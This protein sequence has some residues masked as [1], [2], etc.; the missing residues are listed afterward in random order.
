VLGSGLAGL[1]ERIESPIVIPYAELPDFPQ[2]TVGGHPGRLLL[3]RLAGLPAAILQGR[4]HYYEDGRADAMR[5]AIDAVA[6]LGC[7]R[8][9]LTCAAGSLRA[10]VGPGSIMAVTDHLNLAGVSPL[11]GE[12]GDARFVDMGAAYDPALRQRLQ[13]AAAGTGVTLHDGV[14]AWFAG[15]QFETP[16]EIRAARLLGADAVGM[17]LVPETIL[18]RHAGLAVAAVAA[19]TNLAAGLAPAPFDHRQ[20]L[21]MAGRAAADLGRLVEAF[22]AGLREEVV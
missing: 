18:A 8:L 5:G 13:A 16:A 3:G 4:A 15:P 6:A 11:I 17:S 12:R 22:A 1:A 21:A 9:L 2:P 10:E 7:P 20:T 14:Y 19:V